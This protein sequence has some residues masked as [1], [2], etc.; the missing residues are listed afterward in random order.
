MA[1]LAICPVQVAADIVVIVNPSSEITQLTRRQVIDVYM[2]RAFIMSNG[3]RLQ[4][5]DNA[6]ET[7]IRETFYHQLIGKTLAS[8]NAYWA[9]L[10]FAGRASP[11]R[12][13]AG[14]AAMLKRIEEN[15]NAIGYVDTK[16]LN[17]HVNVVFRLSVD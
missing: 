1:L 2:G 15:P 3:R 9:R 4:P 17:A 7:A 11:P 16:D 6:E 8:V 10:L 5:Y 13:L 14:S 12:R